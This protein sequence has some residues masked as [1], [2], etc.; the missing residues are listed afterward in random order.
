MSRNRQ[1]ET[2][3]VEFSARMELSRENL[4]GEGG[5]YFVWKELPM[6]G[7]LIGMKFSM[8]GEPDF[9]AIFKSDQK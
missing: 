3:W 9:L 7:I 4:P 8:E 2:F 6:E 1:E 5:G